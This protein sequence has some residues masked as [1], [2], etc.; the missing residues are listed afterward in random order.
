MKPNQQKVQEYLE[1]DGWEIASKVDPHIIDWWAD[2]IWKLTSVWSPHGAIAYITFLVDPQHD[3]NR[4]KGEAVW[5][6]GCSKKFPKSPSE[7]QSCASLAFGKSF[8]KGIMDFQTDM[9]SLRVK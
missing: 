8:K 4:R 3:G 7:A 1:L 5:G 2:E 6:V 9:E